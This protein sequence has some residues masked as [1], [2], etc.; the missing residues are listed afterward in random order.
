LHIA[1]SILPFALTGAGL[2]LALGSVAL[3]LLVVMAFLL[4]GGNASAYEQIGAGGIAREEDY[5]GGT[6]PAAAPDSPAAQAERE[7]E[8]RQMLLARSERLVRAG[9]PALDIDAEL[10]RLLDAE[11]ETPPP[12]AGL[13]AEVRA[14]VVARNERRARQGQEPLDVEREVART[15]EELGS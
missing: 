13:L 1:P 9:E 10:A 8:I 5:A 2:G 4:T 6:P 12:D 7:R 3:L 11:Q 15:L 14:L